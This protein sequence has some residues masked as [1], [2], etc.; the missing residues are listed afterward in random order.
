ESVDADSGFRRLGLR[1][2]DVLVALGSER[3]DGA[4]DAERLI[5][6]LRTGQRATLFVER[7]GQMGRVE[8][9]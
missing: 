5:E 8:I 2:G 4:D 3:L 9:R 6:F 7:D 1:E